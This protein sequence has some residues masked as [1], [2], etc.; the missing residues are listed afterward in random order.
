M[1]FDDIQLIK[2]AEEVLPENWEEI[3]DIIHQVDDSDTARI[4]TNIQHS[5]QLEYEDTLYP[6]DTKRT[7]GPNAYKKEQRKN[8][9]ANKMSDAVNYISR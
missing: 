4:I 8:Q 2:E 3:T 1:T 5:K 6:P 7:K 9:A